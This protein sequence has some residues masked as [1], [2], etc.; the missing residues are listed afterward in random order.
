MCH[1]QTAIQCT[2]SQ[3]H[4]EN[5]APLFLW[6][7]NHKYIL[8]FFSVLRCQIRGSRALIQETVI[9]ATKFLQLWGWNMRRGQ[10][11]KQTRLKNINVSFKWSLL[12]R[13]RFKAPENVVSNLKYFSIIL[14]NSWFKWATL[15]VQKN[16]KHSA[17]L[18]HEYCVAVIW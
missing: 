12:L 8:R 7:H 11:V 6:C 5:R 4:L 15:K 2:K 16:K 9:R 18:L 14:H 17:N 1:C 10:I 13:F 3:H